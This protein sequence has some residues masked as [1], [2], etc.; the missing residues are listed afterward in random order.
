MISLSVSRVTQ[1]PPI[2]FPNSA[3]HKGGRPSKN[4]LYCCDAMLSRGLGGKPEIRMRDFTRSGDDKA[5]ANANPAPMELPT[6]VAWVMF[7]ASKNCSKKCTRRVGV[8]GPSGLSD[9]PDPSKSK[10][11]TRWEEGQTGVLIFPIPH[12]SPKTVDEHERVAL[13]RFHVEDLVAGDVDRVSW[14][15]V[16]RFNQ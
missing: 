12:G 1:R 15:A 3:N 2:Q 8:Y 14:N 4:L 10:T 7:R 9:S 11:I 16:N 13:P 6:N 5:T